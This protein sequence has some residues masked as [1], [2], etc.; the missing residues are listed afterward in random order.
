M[1]ILIKNEYRRNEVVHR[2]GEAVWGAMK[3]GGPTTFLSLA[4]RASLFGPTLASLPPS[5][6][7]TYLNSPFLQEWGL[8]FFLYGRCL[9]GVKH[10]KSAVV[11]SRRR[12]G[13]IAQDARRAGS[14]KAPPKMAELSTAESQGSSWIHNVVK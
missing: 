2:E 10:E 14:S 6:P 8:G 11:V 9:K 7:S 5:S 12:G 13:R 3:R 4:E 1:M